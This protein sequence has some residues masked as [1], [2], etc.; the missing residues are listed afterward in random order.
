MSLAYVLLLNNGCR[1]GDP[2]LLI[3]PIILSPNE[4]GIVKFDPQTNIP[5]ARELVGQDF[6][7]IWLLCLEIDRFRVLEIKQI[8]P[9]NTKISEPQWKLFTKLYSA[10]SLIRT[11]LSQ[12]TYLSVRIS[13]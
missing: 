4:G 6:K 3:V 1:D 13:E 8:P 7:V 12:A 9:E 2:L 10:P 5:G 11:P